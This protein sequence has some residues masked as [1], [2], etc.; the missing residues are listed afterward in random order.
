MC[1]II[2]AK[3]NHVQITNYPCIEKLELLIIK[4]KLHLH[5]M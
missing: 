5:G 3:G 1:I 4:D 2:E